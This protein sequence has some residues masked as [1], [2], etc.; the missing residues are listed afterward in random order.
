LALT[1]ARPV[2]QVTRV[3]PPTISLTTWPPASTASTNGTKEYDFWIKGRGKSSPHFCRRHD[4]GLLITRCQFNAASMICV[5]TILKAVW[6]TGWG[7]ASPKIKLTLS[8]KE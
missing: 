2:E 6:G 8:E 7:A 3:K 4:L 1:P 5:L